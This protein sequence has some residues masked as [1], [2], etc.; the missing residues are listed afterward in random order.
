MGYREV[1]LLTNGLAVISLGTFLV[2]LHLKMDSRSDHYETYI[3]L[4][5]L[6]LVTVR[7]EIVDDIN[8]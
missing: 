4:L 1:F 8:I 6:G 2:H 5:P 7:D 3:E